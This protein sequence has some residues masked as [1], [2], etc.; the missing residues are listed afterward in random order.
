MASEQDSPLRDSYNLDSLNG[1]WITDTGVIGDALKHPDNVVIEADPGTGKSYAALEQLGAPEQPF[2]FVADTIASAED[3]GSEHG[4]PV[5]YS[6]KPDPGQQDFITIPH[7]AHKDRFVDSEICLVVDEWHSLIADYGF[8]DAVIDK[9]VQSFAGYGQII[10]LTGTYH[11]VPHS[12]DH[13]TVTQDRDDIAVTTVSYEHL[14]SAIVEQVEARPDKTHFISLYDKSARLKNLRVL[15]ETRGFDA[16]EILAFNADTTDAEEVQALMQQNVTKDD[17]EVIISTYVQGF[18]I[19]DRDYMVHIAPLPGA[20]HSALDI[21]QVAQRFRNTTDLPINL[22]WNFPSPETAA[23]ADKDAYHRKQQD[24]ATSKIREYRDELNLEEGEAP[25][26]MVKSMISASEKDRRQDQTNANDEV[27]LI[28]SDLS[29]N[30]YQ[31][32]HNV[33]S[34]IANNIY[35]SNDRMEYWLQ[36]YGL[37]LEN[38]EDCPI[39]LPEARG[40]SASPQD[41]DEEEFMDKVD[42]HLNSDYVPRTDEA[43]QK[44]LFLMKY[45]DDREHIRSILKDHAQ[46]TQTWNRLKHKIK[47]QAPFTDLEA[48]QN[49]AIKKAFDVGERL[50]SE[51]ILH[52]MQG[53]DTPLMDTSEYSTGEA[54]VRLHRYFETKYTSTTRGGERVALYE[55]MPDNPLPIPLP[56]GVMEA[57]IGEDSLRVDPSKALE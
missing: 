37:T 44:I 28:R 25:S 54:M 45:Y 40:E 5:Y 21:A 12:H 6:G 24:L 17:T 56:E 26:P 47:A 18:S 55:I 43:G 4:L 48:K 9:L 19:K 57:Q 36:R 31:I 46:P 49:A 23:V 39:R 15:L 13:V 14:W 7:H 50:T 1:Q 53:L 8:K 52:R 51:E 10:G 38:T 35:R 32:Y 3:L 22:Y 41:V 16:G 42:E 20:Q 30:Q 27:N 2:I 29:I 34:L 11:P 33:Y